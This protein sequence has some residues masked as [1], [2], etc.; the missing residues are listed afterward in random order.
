LKR[1][2]ARASAVDSI[3]ESGAAPASIQDSSSTPGPTKSAPPPPNTPA[4][5]GPVTPAGPAAS[6]KKRKRKAKA[7][8]GVES[9][10]ISGAIQKLSLDVSPEYPEAVPE[11]NAPKRR[12]R[13]RKKAQPDSAG[14]ATSSLNA[15][16]SVEGDLPLPAATA[17]EGASA[18]GTEKKR[19]RKHKKAEDEVKSNIVAADAAPPIPGSGVAPVD[20]STSQVDDEQKKRKRKRPQKAVAAAAEE[21]VTKSPEPAKGVL[22]AQELKQKR[23]ETGVEKK[24]EKLG[25]RKRAGDSVKESLIGKKGLTTL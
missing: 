11:A 10:P 16:A 18:V 9:T 5:D 7:A 15:I 2:K 21:N 22:S 14:E 12:K 17:P 23:S 1:K 24:K 13:S 3:Q 19:K 20:A 6:E 25:R 4:D 8:T